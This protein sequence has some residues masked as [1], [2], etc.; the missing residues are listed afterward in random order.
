MLIFRGGYWPEHRRWA[1]AT[2]AITL[3]AALWCGVEWA[4]LGRWPGGGSPPGLTLGIA[5][6][7]II[8][9]EMLLWPRKKF[10]LLKV[11]RAKLWMKAH[12]WL[13]LLSLPLIVMHGGFHLGGGALTAALMVE[14][15]AV[16]FNGVWGL[17]VQQ[18]LPRSML[19]NV[20]AETIRSQVAPILAQY[21]DEAGR[22][23]RMTCGVEEP[24]TP[25]PR[26]AHAG[27]N[28]RILQIG[29]IRT[30]GVAAGDPDRSRARV[31]RVPGSLPLLAFFEETVRPYLEASSGSG[32]ALAP[33][34][35]SAA[36]FR[37][38][39][40]WL[41]P[42]AHEAVARLEE[43]CERR[44]QFDLQVRLHRWLHNWVGVHVPLAA[45]MFVLML[46]HVYF[47]A[48]FR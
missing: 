19:E 2:L 25:G 9:F 24:R 12:I 43:L 37:D 30:P 45:S 15:L 5:G 10:R 17:A 6:G 39:R 34:K 38:V 26:L 21:L 16:I 13:G 23:V 40:F 47:A 29:A 41:D 11:G 44:R 3:A 32:S 1:R 7:L 33:A 42:A 14:F 31:P 8:V 28:G 27:V 18:Y 48:K 46:A 35:R 22:I 20:P 36:I 4:R